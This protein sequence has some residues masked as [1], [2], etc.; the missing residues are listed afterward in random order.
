MTMMLSLQMMNQ[1][2]VWLQVWPS[3]ALCTC[4][5]TQIWTESSLRKVLPREYPPEQRSLQRPA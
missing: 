3:A 5:S 4:E 1:S 2:R